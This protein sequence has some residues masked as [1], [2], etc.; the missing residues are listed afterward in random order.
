MTQCVLLG[1]SCLSCSLTSVPSWERMREGLGPPR[2]RTRVQVEKSPSCGRGRSCWLRPSLLTV[3]SWWSPLSPTTDEAEG[4]VLPWQGHGTLGYTG[5]PRTLCPL[6]APPPCPGSPFSAQLA[7]GCFW[8]QVE[9]QKGVP[10][11]RNAHLIPSCC[12]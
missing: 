3:Q 1:L 9:V 7:W 2:S 12:W 4:A 5:A 10:L 8:G 6:W 11:Q